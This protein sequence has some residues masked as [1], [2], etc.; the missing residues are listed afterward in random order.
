MRIS[1][2]SSDVCSSDI[3]DQTMVGLMHR[4]ADLNVIMVNDRYCEI[5]G[6][7]SAEL[8]GLPMQA[9]THPADVAWNIELFDTHARTGEP[10]MPDKRYVRPDGTVVW[11]ENNVSFEI[12]R[13]SCRES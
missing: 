13:T 6:R 9:F 12:G 8:C 4:D 2:W 1:D 11:C 3:F 10:F 7:S 5:V